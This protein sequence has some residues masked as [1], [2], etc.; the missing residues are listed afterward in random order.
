[1]IIRAWWPEDSPDAIPPYAEYAI[2]MLKQCLASDDVD[3]I[4]GCIEKEV[5][6]KLEPIPK[7]FEQIKAAIN[8][9][10]QRP[11][12]QRPHPGV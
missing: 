1:M 10:A 2:Y 9:L 11:P 12:G 7:L 4:K 6:P 8:Q 5:L 3:G